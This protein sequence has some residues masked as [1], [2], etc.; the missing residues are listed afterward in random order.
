MQQLRLSVEDNGV[1]GLPNEI[2]WKA[3]GFLCPTDVVYASRSCRQIH[4]S[5]SHPGFV[6]EYIQLH[7]ANDNSRESPE[8]SIRTLEQLTF[9]QSIEVRELHKENRIGFLIATV[10]VAPDRNIF[11]TGL[12]PIDPE[13]VN[14]QNS[15]TR[16]QLIKNLIRRHHEGNLHIRVDAHCGIIAPEVVAA[17][18]AIARAEAVQEALTDA[19]TPTVPIQT[20]GWGKMVADWCAEPTCNHKFGP[21]A[22]TGLGWAEIYLEL[23]GWKCPPRP[24]FYTLWDDVDESSEGTP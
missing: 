19:I 21:L 1:L 15:I 11:T 10:E 4:K 5:L 24:S 7:L 20:V 17:G 3:A 13:K 18:Y 23:D 16:I 2:L 6:P 8:N 22:R 9:L 14:V 12:L